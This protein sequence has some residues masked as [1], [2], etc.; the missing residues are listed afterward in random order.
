MDEQREEE[1][2]EEREP[3]VSEEEKA[4]VLSDGGGNEMRPPKKQ[5]RFP[6]VRGLLTGVIVMAALLIVFSLVNLRIINRGGSVTYSD[7]TLLDESTEDKIAT[8]AG[9]IEENYYEDVEIEDLR[10][11]L[12]QG[13]FD[14]LD[15]Y[16]QYYTVE[17]YGDLLESE[18]EGVYCGIGVTLQQDAETMLVTVIRVYDGS[19]AQEAGL[20]VGDFVYKAEGYDATTMELSELVTHIRGEEGTTVHLDVYRDGEEL[21]F[22]IV[23]RNLDYPTVVYDMLDGDIGY[24]EVSEFA[25]TTAG[26]FEEAI[27]ALTEQGMEALI[28]DLR[29]NPGGMLD[30]VCDMLDDI[31][32]EGLILYTEDRDGRRVNYDTTDDRSLDVPLAVLVNAS[33]ASASEIFAG[34]VQ[35]RDAGVIIG[36]TTF[37]KGVVQT[38]RPLSD[39]TA[40]KL[41]T[42]R[43]FTPGGT[44]IQGIGITPDIEIDYEF[45]GGEEDAYSYDLDNQIEEAVKVLKE[46]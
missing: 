21:E 43:Y 36:T 20:Q 38:I 12:Y 4:P 24:I 29:Y 37:G 41:T 39:G 40:V 14:N 6:F 10:E 8:L 28:V 23:R 7:R 18:I 27:D 11:G 30:A 44:C 9:Y 19:P 5:R 15:V 33:S 16:S 42:S 26:R 25:E 46:E 2:E 1:R 34:A 22:D 17:E 3:D 35:D 32:P 31:L 45:L 13:L